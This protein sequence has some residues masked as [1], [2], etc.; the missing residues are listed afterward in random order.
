MR[1]LSWEHNSRGGSKSCDPKLLGKNFSDSPHQNHMSHFEHWVILCFVECLWQMPEI[2]VWNIKKKK[3][4]E[5]RGP[6]IFFSRK[7]GDYTYKNNLE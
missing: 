2:R 7:Q 3:H 5:F 4:D 1:V 6:I